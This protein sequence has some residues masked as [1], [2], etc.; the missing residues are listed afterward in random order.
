[1]TATLTPACPRCGGDHL[2]DRCDA[3]MNGAPPLSTHE[4]ETVQRMMVLPIKTVWVSLFALIISLMFNTL[5]VG[6]QVHYW[7]R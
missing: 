3:P 2:V 7:T 1:M 5:L 6:F 4:E